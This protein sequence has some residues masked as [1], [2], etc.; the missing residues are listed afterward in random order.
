MSTHHRTTCRTVAALLTGLFATAALCS[1]AHAAPRWIRLSWTQS[2]AT[3]MTVAWSDDTNGA[4]EAEIREPGG[5]AVNVT[6]TAEDTGISELDVTY[7][8]TFTGLTPATHYEYRVHSAGAWSPWFS[9]RTAPPA[10]S[11]APFNFVSVGD[12]RGEEIPIWG[13]AQSQ[14]WPGVM[15]LIAAEHPLFVIHS[16]D[17]VHD[18]DIAEQWEIELDDL[19]TISSVAPFLLAQGNHDDGPGEGA[20]AHFN[21][22]FAYPTSN[23]DTTEDYFSLVM[24]NVQVICL[25]THSFDMDDQ[26]AWMDTELTAQQG[27]VDWRVV[28]FHVPI[29]SSGA[30]G[31]NEDDT[32][33]AAVM[34]PVLESHGVDL[35]INGHDHD[36][37]R[38]HPSVGGHGAG[39]RVSTPCPRTP[40]P[41][42]WPAAWST[43]SPAAPAPW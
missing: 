14:Q 35:V 7:V 22:L 41:G 28:F 15:S 42:A 8:A 10:G 39:T 40:A 2:P 38:F 5:T 25:S 29:W 26:I 12:G 33:R 24:G 43:T 16:G 30:H 6:A 20:T 31:S 23:P 1:Q 9:T 11:C 36:Y 18:G 27:V 13:Y 32:P 19:M 4:A 37:E 34:L 21:K 17:Y 3:T